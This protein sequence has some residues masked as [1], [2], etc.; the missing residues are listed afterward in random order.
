MRRTKILVPAVLLALGALAA[1][2]AASSA[3]GRSQAAPTNTKEPFIGAPY[4]VKVGTTLQGNRGSWSGTV[5]ISFTYQWG[6]CNEDAQACKKITNATGTSYTVVNAD[7]GHT[8]RFQVTASNA[9]GKTTAVSNATS[10]IPAEPGAPIMASP[11]TVVGEAIVGQQLSATPGNWQGTEP[12]SYTYKWQECN[13]AASSCAGN[14]YSGKTYSVRKGDV[15]K[16]LRVKVVAKNSVGSTP[17][18]SAPTTVVSEE[19]S[20]IITL[21]NGE[22]SIA[23]TAI[24]DDE[25]LIVDQVKFTPNPVTSRDNPF[26]VRIKVED[27]ENHVVRGALV[28]IRST[29]ILSSVPTDAPTGQ[30]GWIT[31]NIQPRHDWPL[32]NGANVQFF[33]KAYRQGDPT[34]AGI[35]GDRLVQVAVASP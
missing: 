8:L 5:P 13:T 24:P 22:K 1:L 16:R 27:T 3:T 7:V 25:R 28:F 26:Q 19:G 32:K 21:P 30:D 20:G 10:L 17:G 31:Y 14:G 6:R 15:G 29:P 23:V 2:F 35:R 18:L 12:I 34:L 9:D 4:L 33:V 11:P